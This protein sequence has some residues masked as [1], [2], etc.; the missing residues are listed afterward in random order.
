MNGDAWG[1][2]KSDYHRYRQLLTVRKFVREV[3]GNRGLRVCVWMR[4]ANST[5]NPIMRRIYTRLY[6]GLSHK[7]GIQIPPGTII[8][9]GLYIGHGMCVVV[10][11]KTVIGDNCSLSQ[12]TTIG[13]NHD[14]P[15]HIGHNVYIGPGTCIVENVTIG[16]NAIIGAG[17]V[18]VHDVPANCTVAGNP[19]KIISQ[20]SNP[21]L[22]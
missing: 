8:G 18:V 4:L 11:P 13:S 21:P 1:Y 16:D 17:S 12:F 10:H 2:I 6:V 3:R 5:K 7:T 22:R 9:G 14:T 19:A 15:A 20:K